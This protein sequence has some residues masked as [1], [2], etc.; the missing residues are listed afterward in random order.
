MG[1]LVQRDNLLNPLQWGFVQAH[2]SEALTDILSSTL[3][4]GNWIKK[5]EVVLLLQDFKSKDQKIHSKGSERICWYVCHGNVWFCCLSWKEFHSCDTPQAFE[6]LSCS[7]NHK[8]FEQMTHNSLAVLPAGVI[9]MKGFFSLS[10]VYF[11]L[12]LFQLSSGNVWK[13]LSVFIHRRPDAFCKLPWMGGSALNQGCSWWC[14]GW[15]GQR[16]DSC[17]WKTW[18]EW[19]IGS[20][21][22]KSPEDNCVTWLNCGAGGCMQVTG[23][24]RSFPKGRLCC[25]IPSSIQHENWV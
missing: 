9:A 20:G 21:N 6:L 15:A 7:S 3:P 11:K 18:L 1:L 14:P 23:K 10:C 19:S 17:L 8:L 12:S 24:E 25:W 13:R 4:T 5:W 22:V 2:T 16:Q